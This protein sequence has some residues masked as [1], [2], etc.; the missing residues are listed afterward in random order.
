M[1]ALLMYSS[2]P[3]SNTS[4]V[5]V[6]APSSGAISASS[7]GA[8]RLSRR[9]RSVIRRSADPAPVSMSRLISPP[10]PG[11]VARSR[12]VPSPVSAGRFQWSVCTFAAA[13]RAYSQRSARCL[14]STRPS[15]PIGRS[16]TGASRS[17]SG[18][19]KGLKG[20]P[21]SSIRTRIAAGGGRTS[22][23]AVRPGCP[24]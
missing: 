22:T 2:P 18:S 1:P 6:A 4:D 15:P 20:G 8:V 14:T 19:S 21:A 13:T 9:P 10:C 11:S 17:G 7:L 24:P 16:A 3:S 23:C 5:T 12:N